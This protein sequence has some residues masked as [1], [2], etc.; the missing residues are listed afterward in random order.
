M[1][2]LFQLLSALRRRILERSNLAHKLVDQIDC[3]SSPDGN[4][5]VLMRAPRP[6]AAVEAELVFAN[7]PH[8]ANTVTLV[9]IFDKP[10]YPSYFRRCRARGFIDALELTTIHRYPWTWRQYTKPNGAVVR[11]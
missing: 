11:M 8:K 6:L 10:N 5:I 3:Y 7:A 2:V 4:S 9:F 1:S